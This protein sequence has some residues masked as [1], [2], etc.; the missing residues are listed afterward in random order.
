MLASATYGKPFPALV[1]RGYVAGAQFHPEK[2]GP[3]G[4]RLLR[5]FGAL[6]AG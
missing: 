4:L 2:S 5:N 1:G 6:T 3:A